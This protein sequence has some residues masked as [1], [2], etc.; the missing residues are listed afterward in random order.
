MPRVISEAKHLI[1]LLGVTVLGP[2]VAVGRGVA[3][4]RT[5]ANLF[6]KGVLR[7]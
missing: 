2:R 4:E 5:E 6:K 1:P 3:L 7:V